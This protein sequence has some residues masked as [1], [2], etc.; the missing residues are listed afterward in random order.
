MGLPC[1]NQD[2]LVWRDLSSSESLSGSRA[3]PEPSSR[4]GHLKKRRMAGLA[5][6]VF[7]FLIRWALWYSIFTAFFKSRFSFRKL[8]ITQN[9][10]SAPVV[11]S[12][13]LRKST[14]SGGQ[15]TLTCKGKHCVQTCDGGGCSLECDGNVCEQT[16][17][18]ED[19]CNLEC[20]R[21]NCNQKCNQQCSLECRGERCTQD[22]SEVLDSCQLQCPVVI[23]PTKRCQQD[24]PGYKKNCCTT[25]YISRT[26][27][28]TV[29]SEPHHSC[30]GE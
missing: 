13:A 7:F 29:F 15:C 1:L 14:F 19:T 22:C 25:K 26:K 16:C 8:Y 9:A 4:S 10:F 5:S 23:D 2:E 28:S 11:N 20:L 6:T 27:T 30:T 3:L 17:R 12:G 24:C 21:G 18:A